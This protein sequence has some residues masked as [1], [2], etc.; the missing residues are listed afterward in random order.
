MRHFLQLLGVASILGIGHASTPDI[1]TDISVVTSL[2]SFNLT[3]S[4]AC[5]C[6]KLSTLYPDLVIFPDSANYT[7][8]ATYYWDIR[9][10]LSPACIFLPTTA[11]EVATSVKQL[12][13]CDAQFAVRGGGHM[14]VS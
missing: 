5:A 9:A 10:D 2:G 7:E 12:V 8:Q 1:L 13:E 11:D 4:A 6:K 14:N 3:T